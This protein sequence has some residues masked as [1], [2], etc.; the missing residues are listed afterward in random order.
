MRELLLKTEVIRLVCLVV[1]LTAH[2]VLPTSIAAQGEDEEE[3]FTCIGC[4][5]EGQAV[6]CCAYGGDN[7]WDECIPYV[8]YCELGEYCVSP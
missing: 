5:H 6:A 2:A 1:L 4:L 8:D 7:S 3:C